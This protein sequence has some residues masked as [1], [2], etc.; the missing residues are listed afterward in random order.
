MDTS[1]S[2]EKCIYLGLKEGTSRRGKA[3]YA[4]TISTQDLELRPLYR[5]GIPIPLFLTLCKFSLWTLR[6]GLLP[7]YQHS[8][9]MKQRMY[10]PCKFN[11]ASLRYGQKWLL[12]QKGD[13]NNFSMILPRYQMPHEQSHPRNRGYIQDVRSSHSMVISWKQNIAGKVLLILFF[14]FKSQSYILKTNKMSS[15]SVQS[16]EN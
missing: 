13:N 9:Q 11:L 8:W 2:N 7:P 12:W 1:L 5:K 6:I 3:H 4:N 10:I 14:I 15:N 16:S